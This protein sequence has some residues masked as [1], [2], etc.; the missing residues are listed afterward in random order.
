[1]ID[2]SPMYGK[3]EQVV[4]DLVAETRLRPKTFIATKVWTQ[5]RGAGEAQMARSA[6]LL[7]A[8][9]LDLIQIHNLLDWKT[10]LRTLRRWKDESHVRYIGITHYHDGAH[11]EL[12][13]VMR[14]EPVDF[15]QFN[16]ALDD[17][18]AEHTLL[19]LAAERGIAVIVNRPFASGDLIRRLNGRPLPDCAVDLDCTD[20]SQVA[21]KYIAAHEA[22]TCIIPATG[23]PEHMESNARA[24]TGVLPDEPMRREI[25]AAAG[26]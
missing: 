9:P 24:G 17:H 1:M 4:G 14:S 16:Y 26:L 15:V 10:H 8:D 20:W 23:N 19:P 3:A 25:L 6:A 2:S 12:A 18:A 5:G 7:K 22:V 21:L 13:E 11:S